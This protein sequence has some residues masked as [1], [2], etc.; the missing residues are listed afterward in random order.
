MR[1]I[2][3]SV[4]YI[5]KSG[6]DLVGLS[7]VFSDILLFTFRCYVDTK[8]YLVE[9]PIYC[10][11]IAV[12]VQELAKDKELKRA[13][14]EEDFPTITARL[15]VYANKNYGRYSDKSCIIPQRD[16]EELIP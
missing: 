12:T 4:Q 1:I 15:A 6:K 14:A 16:L 9:N 13:V 10:T 8:P 3:K 11:R 7:W 5:L 2:S